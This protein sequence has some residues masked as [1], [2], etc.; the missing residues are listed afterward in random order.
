MFQAHSQLHSTKPLFASTVVH[1]CVFSADPYTVRKVTLGWQTGINILP[2]RH[3][4][5]QFELFFP[6]FFIPAPRHITVIRHALLKT[7]SMGLSEHEATETCSLCPWAHLNAVSSERASPQPP[8]KGSLEWRQRWAGPS[9]WRG[10]PPGDCSQLSLTASSWR[11]TKTNITN[12]LSLTVGTNS[13]FMFISELKDY[14]SISFSST[15]L[16]QMS[17]F[18]CL[19]VFIF[20]VFL[21]GKNVQNVLVSLQRQIMNGLL[22]RPMDL[23]CSEGWDGINRKALDARLNSK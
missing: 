11:L 21:L 1:M 19:A 3:A 4:S 20:T 9:L 17:V 14:I 13:V 10:L 6:F 15:F 23:Q 22:W 18:I 7:P 8:S 2:Q 16:K 12:C 5:N